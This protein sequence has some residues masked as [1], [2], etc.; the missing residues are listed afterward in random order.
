MSYAVIRTGGKQ[1]RV[2]PGDTVRVDRLA[3]K[4]GEKVTF[5][6][7]LVVGGPEPKI[8]KGKVA[9]ASVEGEIVGEVLGDKLVVFKF[10]RRKRSRKKAGHRQAYTAVKITKVKG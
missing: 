10:R 9:G 5:D 2:A 4:A 7:V 6:D 3:G 8:G 1:Y